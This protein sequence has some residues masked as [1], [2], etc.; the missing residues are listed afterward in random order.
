ML[1]RSREALKVLV[2]DDHPVV[3]SG[4]RLMFSSDDSIHLIS[5]R[6]EKS[7]YRCYFS[8]H[9][10]VTILD[11]NLPD[12]SGFELLRKIRKGDAGAKIIIFSMNDGPSFVLR[13]VEL[14]AR[15]YVS[16]TDDP[17]LLLSAVRKVAEGDTFIS[18]HL[19]KAV[20]FSAASVRAH[21]ASQLSSREVEILRLLARGKKLIE[22][23]DS[24]DVSYKTIANSTSL[25]KQKLG[26]RSHS[27]LIRLAVEMGL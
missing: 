20:T 8:E 17:E 19:A 1:A 4:C 6:D 14:G 7:G 12:L 9:P 13:A 10:D 27:D 15:G 24:M 5:A 21:P 25:M 18:P 2:V 26:A 11:I 23:A 22:I 16:K 3:I